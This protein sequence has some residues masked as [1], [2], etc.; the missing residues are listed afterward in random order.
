VIRSSGNY[1]KPIPHF[2]DAQPA[3]TRYNR[4]T[5]PHPKLN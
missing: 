3:P 2:G 4:R 5:C 1:L